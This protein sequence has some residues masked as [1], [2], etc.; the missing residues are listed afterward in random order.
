MLVYVSPEFKLHPEFLTSVQYIG[1]SDK[2]G[3]KSVTQLRDEEL[4]LEPLL[5]TLIRE[6]PLNEYELRVV[7]GRCFKF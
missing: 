1:K 2:K 4:G 5:K 3:T 7:V 6:R